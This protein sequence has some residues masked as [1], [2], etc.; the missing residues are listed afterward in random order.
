MERKEKDI[1]KMALYAGLIMLRNGGETYRVEETM[2]RICNA[3]GIPTA[4]TFVTPTGIFLSIDRESSS[5]TSD[6]GDNA[7]F[8]FQR[9]VR[10]RS[11]DLSKVSRVNDFSRTFDPEKN[12]IA[13]AMEL[14]RE[15]DGPP[16]FSLW[17]RSLF[18]GVAS[19]SF[20][21]MNGGRLED[22]LCSLFIGIT[23]YSLIA[24]H[25][26]LQENTFIKTLIA[27]AFGSALAVFCG[28]FQLAASTDTVIIGAIMIL[29]PG[30]AI[31]NAIRDSL[32]GDILSGMI[33]VFE[34]FINSAAIAVGVGFVIGI[35]TAITGGLIY[36]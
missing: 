34:A 32:S 22:I 28:H 24:F 12:T 14:L 4:E 6:Q 3:C 30:V 36:G 23:M 7:T 20:T 29:L 8:T 5:R 15:I 27:A 1:L 26:T 2:I 10:D 13:E 31:T 33:R 18:A 9:R 16:Q 11:I 35:Y 19:A 25:D 21:G 17:K